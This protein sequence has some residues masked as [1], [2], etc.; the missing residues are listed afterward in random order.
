MVA[1]I[2]NRIQQMEKRISDEEDSIENVDTTFKENVKC[3][4]TLT[5]SI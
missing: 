4:K 1:S 5:Q 3:K 2:N